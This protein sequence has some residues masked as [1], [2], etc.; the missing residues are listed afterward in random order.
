[1]QELLC[2]SLQQVLWSCHSD[3]GPIAMVTQARI[4]EVKLPVFQAMPRELRPLDCIY[5]VDACMSYQI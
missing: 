1:M 4:D 2:S 5:D 3:Y